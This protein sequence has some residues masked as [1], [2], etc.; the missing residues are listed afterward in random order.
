MA[1]KDRLFAAARSA[2]GQPQTQGEK[3]ARHSAHAGATTTAE[4]A[5]D[6]AA[7]P[8]TETHESDAQETKPTAASA[9]KPEADAKEAGAAG[10]P[11]AKAV[12]APPPA[13][14][15]SPA[16]TTPLEAASDAAA[17]PKTETEGA[18][19]GGAKG[20]P[21]GE[22]KAKSPEPLVGAAA[23]R[24][25]DA[26]IKARAAAAA[27][28]KASGHC[29]GGRGRGRGRRGDQRTKSGTK[30]GTKSEVLITCA[31]KETAP[32]CGFLR[33]FGRVVAAMPAG[34]ASAVAHARQHQCPVYFVLKD[35]TQKLYGP[36]S[37]EGVPE[38]PIPE[39]AA[40]FPAQLV[41]RRMTS[42]KCVVLERGVS[43]QLGRGYLPADIA[44]AGRPPLRALSQNTPP[45]AKPAA[46]SYVRAATREDDEAHAALLR[47]AKKGMSA[48]RAEIAARKKA[49]SVDERHAERVAR[50]LAARGA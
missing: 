23:K 25:Y 10:V 5:S 39:L 1:P 20:V 28:A 6:A 42:T 15:P 37:I 18:A 22:G 2:S 35:R 46:V 50:N 9:P 31:T 17:S 29:R 34:Y 36:Y 47:W 43:L 11:E 16:P 33:K 24:A 30:S 49:L 8:E 3:D 38:A 41:L 27:A 7:S 32:F 19:E 45:R 44:E 12:P 21:E 13:P 26:K 40:R 14:A 48:E 4:A